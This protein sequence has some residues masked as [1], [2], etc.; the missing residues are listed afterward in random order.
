[1]RLKL[2]LPIIDPEQFEE[3]EHCVDPKCSGQRFVPW[4]AVKKNVRDSEYEE[5]VAR[6]YKCLRCGC[7]FRVYPQGVQKSQIS[8][9]VKGMGVMLY[10]LGLSYGAASLMLEALGVYLSTPSRCPSG[11]VVCIERCKRRRK[12]C[13]G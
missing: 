11:K 10:L 2:I 12:R 13:R 1:M 8:Q 3:P 4:Q 9:R 6:R 5:V 7:T